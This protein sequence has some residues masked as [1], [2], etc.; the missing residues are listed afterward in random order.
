VVEAAMSEAL[1][2]VKDLKVA[3]ENKKNKTTIVDGISFHVNKGETL[4]VVGESGCGKSL[5]SLSIM[6]LLPKT[7]KVD[8]G[9]ILFKDD[10]LSKKTQKQMSKIRGKK[11]S[12]IFQEPMTSLNP[13]HTVGRQIM[14]TI[15]L[16]EKMN[17][18]AARQRAIDMLKLVG[19]P[20]PEA[21]IDAYPHELSGGMRQRVMIAIALSC[22]PELLIADEPTTALDVTIQAQILELMKKLQEELNMGIIMITHDL[23]VV[24]EVADE[25]LVMY[26]GKAVEQASRD[27]LFEK[28]LHPYTQG[29]LNCIPTINNEEEKEELFVIKGTV[30]TAD[31]MPVGCR[32]ADR[33]P[34]AQEVCFA[35]QPPT[36]NIDD[37]R[38]AC[39]SYTEQ[40]NHQEGGEQDDTS[41]GDYQ[42]AISS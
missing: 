39:W 3:F 18:K 6:G 29:L 31:N 21:R 8:G 14:E 24:S 1:L 17:K 32:F 4:C 42:Q 19:I 38:V 40:W 9:Q 28:P 13:V 34:I 12:M 16:H 26:A 5:T 33:C 27:Q 20:S 37:H 41:A 2:N 36:V 10:D 22:Q 25:V 11:L 30:P 15:M 23:A 7:G 35:S